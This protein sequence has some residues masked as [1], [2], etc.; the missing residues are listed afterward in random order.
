M[1]RIW[2]TY[3]RSEYGVVGTDDVELTDDDVG[4]DRSE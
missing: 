2:S 1:I 4:L 3:D